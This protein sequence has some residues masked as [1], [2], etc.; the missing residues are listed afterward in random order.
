MKMKVKR[1]A[2]PVKAC[3]SLVLTTVI[4]L[5]PAS[6][7]NANA[8]TVCSGIAVVSRTSECKLVVDSTAKQWAQFQELRREWKARCGATSSITEMSMLEPYQRIIGMG[9]SAVPAILAQLK[10]EGDEPDQW[11]W[12][13]RMMTGE[14]PVKPEDQGDFLAMA[15][16]WITWGE[17]KNYAG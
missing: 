10:A 7:A 14:N 8:Q 17:I 1:V 3:F 9:E 15:R 6:E 12:A 16:A 11:F 4:W 13:L 5:Y 2:A